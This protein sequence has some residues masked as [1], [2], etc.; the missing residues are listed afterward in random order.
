[1]QWLHT[2]TYGNEFLK[3]LAR[4]FTEVGVLEHVSDYY[5][6]NVPRGDTTIGYAFGLIETAKAKFRIS[7]YSA[8]QTTLEQ[9]F[10]A[11]AKVQIQG[12]A[13]KTLYRAQSSDQD[14]PVTVE[15]TRGGST[16]E[17]QF[18]PSQWPKILENT[19]SA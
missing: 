17:I 13:G 2:E 1:M 15:K 18:T 8:S 5:K 12:Q 16:A 11:F 10:Q 4:E 6:L 3:F 14:C 9:I 19:L 7:E